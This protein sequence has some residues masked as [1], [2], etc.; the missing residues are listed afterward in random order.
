MLWL[1]KALSVHVVSSAVLQRIDVTMNP[2]LGFASAQF[3]GSSVPATGKTI[4]VPIRMGIPAMTKF[5]VDKMPYF[6]TMPS[7]GL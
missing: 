5:D 4:N 6:T 1:K 7:V 2:V 3:H